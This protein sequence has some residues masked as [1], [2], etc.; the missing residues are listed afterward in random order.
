MAKRRRSP[1]SRSQSKSSARKTEK[2]QPGPPERR[3]GEKSPPRQSVAQSDNSPFPTVAIGASAGGS[4]ALEK[5][6]D[7]MP[8]NS[9]MAFVVNPPPAPR[10]RAKGHPAERS[11]VRAGWNL[12]ARIMVMLEDDSGREQAD[13]KA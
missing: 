2:N 12:P 8:P 4:Q 6:F 1:A 10:H 7:H 5:F 9:G 13:E 11:S 3:L